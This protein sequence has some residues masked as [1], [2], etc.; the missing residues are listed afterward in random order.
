MKVFYSILLLMIFLLASCDYR[1]TNSN[2]ENT[3]ENGDL[4]NLF[5]DQNQSLTSEQ[6]FQ[7]EREKLIAE[8]WQEQEISTGNFPACYN[9]KPKKGRLDNYLEVYVGSGTD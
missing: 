4:N 8:D 2:T 5:S 7:K 6:K 3:P 1:G 9:F